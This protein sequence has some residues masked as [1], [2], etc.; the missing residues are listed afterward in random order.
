MTSS[1]RD[2]GGR[3]SSHVGMP[4]AYASI[5]ATRDPDLLRFPPEGS[6][7][8]EEEQRLGSGEERFLS[9]SSLLM[10]WGAQRGAGM[11]VEVVERGPDDEYEGVEF[12]EHGVAQ[13]AAPREDTFGPDGEPYLNAG[14]SADIALQGGIARRVL[15]VYTV[16]EERRVGFAWGTGDELGAIGEQRFVVE[17]RDDDTVWAVAR[18]F[19][20]P[21]KNGLLGLKA[22]ADLRAAIDAVKLQI[23]ALAPGAAATATAGASTG[24]ARAEAAAEPEA[25]AQPAETSD[26]SEAAAE[27][28]DS[29]ESAT[30][31]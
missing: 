6:T 20:T 4:A 17:R 30:G 8:Y 5:G 19:L 14:T 7:P 27:P 3:R 13:A 9:A 10:T 16:D 25:T 21:A 2:H 11:T 29:H 26:H 22:R 28:A 12:D 18:G 1:N 24:T 23:G 31:E 15:I